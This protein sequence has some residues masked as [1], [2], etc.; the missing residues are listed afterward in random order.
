[1]GKQQ[2]RN[3]Y[4]EL[5]RNIRPHNRWYSNEIIARYCLAYFFIKMF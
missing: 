4:R 3:R 2:N 1:M 5:C